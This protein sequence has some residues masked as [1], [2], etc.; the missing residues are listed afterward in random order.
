MSLSSNDVE[1]EHLKNHL[2]LK[3]QFES[4]SGAFNDQNS[5]FKLKTFDSLL[6]QENKIKNLSSVMH[7]D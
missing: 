3:N 5:Q 1:S 7:A 2:R 4:Y 6:K